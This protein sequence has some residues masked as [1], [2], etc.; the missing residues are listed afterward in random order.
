MV[1]AT[2]AGLEQ[3]LEGLA[4]GEVAGRGELEEAGGLGEERGV[5]R[6]GGDGVGGDAAAVEVGGEA[7]DEA[8]DPGLRGAVGGEARHARGSRRR[9]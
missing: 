7:A 4:G 3:A 6:A 1:A 2:S 5:G 9:R 8:L